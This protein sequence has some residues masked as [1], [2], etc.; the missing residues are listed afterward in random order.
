MNSCTW[1]PREAFELL[2]GQVG[3]GDLAHHDPLVAHAHVHAL[4]L[5]AAPLPELTQGLGDHLGLLDLAVLH[6]TGGSGT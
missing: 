6:G 3:Q 5:E 1:K 4:G 2:L